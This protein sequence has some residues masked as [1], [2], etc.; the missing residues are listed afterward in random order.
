MQDAI[1]TPT[2]T[3]VNSENG[4]EDVYAEAKSGKIRQVIEHQDTMRPPSTIER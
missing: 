4:V 2:K 1:K 3:V